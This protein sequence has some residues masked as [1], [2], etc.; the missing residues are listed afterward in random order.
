MQGERAR[1]TL[2]RVAQPAI[3]PGALFELLYVRPD[4]T[5]R[6][7]GIF[8]RD[9]TLAAR[10]M[11]VIN[12]AAMGV[13]L[14]VTSVDRAV[15]LLGAGRARSIGLAHG[16]RMLA[17]AAPLPPRLVH[18]FWAAAV[19]K[20]AAASLFMRHTAGELADR[21]FAAGLVQ[22]IGLPMLAHVDAAWYTQ[23]LIPGRDEAQWDAA[24][25]RQLGIDHAQ[26]GVSLLNQWGAP[27]PLIASVRTHHS[28]LGQ[29][30]EGDDEALFDLAVFTAGLLP[31]AWEQ[32]AERQRHWLGAIHTRFLADRYPTPDAFVEAAVDEARLIMG[33]E[34]HVSAEDQQR[35]QRDIL[36]HV[37]D[38][39]IRT[40]ANLCRIESRLLRQREGFED[41]RRKAYTDALTRVLN[42]RG[43]G[44]LAERRLRDA[45]HAGQSVCCMMIDVDDFKHTN[46]TFGHR[47]G[48]L[49]LRSVG[50][51]LRR[52]V[53]KQDVI[54]RIGGD[55]FAVFIT[56][57]TPDEAQRFTHMIARAIDGGR[58]RVGDVTLEV[59]VSIGSIHVADLLPMLHVDALLEA[60]D[61]AMYRC[62]RDDSASVSFASIAP[63]D[64]NRPANDHEAA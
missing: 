57:V 19:T 63:A 45:L 34:P 39:M 11:A 42:R 26:V 28:P 6:I 4:E 27:Q 52:A 58:V 24:E 17:E 35:L 12:S 14:E 64:L 7:I 46:D 62:K 29:L 53:R 20:A 18:A 8:K 40:V 32:P 3:R 43:F 13:S 2:R 1:A 56:N 59:N 36:G 37:S 48:D 54:G 44:V 51:V 38:D 23:Q 47:A 31:H 41:L 33:R 60:A 21:A 16:L 55:E 22:D 5:E 61:A 49:V 10:V 25:R 15:H 9:P 50:R 30:P